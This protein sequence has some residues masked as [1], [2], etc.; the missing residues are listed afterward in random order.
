MI[1]LRVLSDMPP[2]LELVH[3]SP[4][5]ANARD[6]SGRTPLHWAATLGL[7]AEAQ[8]LV[9]HGAGIGARDNDGRI[10]LDAAIRAGHQELVQLLGPRPSHGIGP[11]TP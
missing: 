4:C 7:M 8:Y 1:P 5:P 3:A 6:H 10:P 9:A 11:P 2:F